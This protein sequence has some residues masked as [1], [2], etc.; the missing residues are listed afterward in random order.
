MAS[1]AGLAKDVI[2]LM[3]KKLALITGELDEATGKNALLQQRIS[4][5]ETENAQLQQKTS[6]SD[7]LAGYEE[8]EIAEGVFVRIEKNLANHLRSARKLCPNCYNEGRASTLQQSEVSKGRTLLL[9]CPNPKCKA[10]FPFV[11]YIDELPPN[12]PGPQ[13]M[14]TGGRY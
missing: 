13:L 11:C 14:S 9:S 4:Q 1:T 10:Q 8:K 7:P 5:L 2:D 12:P 6:T 3:E